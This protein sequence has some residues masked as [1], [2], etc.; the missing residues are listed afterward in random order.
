MRVDG[1]ILEKGV[2]AG[3]GFPVGIKKSGNKAVLLCGDLPGML[4][5]REEC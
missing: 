3:A 5:I 2:A 4:Q 1:A